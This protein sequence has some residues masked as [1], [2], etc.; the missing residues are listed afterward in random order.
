[1][2]IQQFPIIIL[3]VNAFHCLVLI[4]LNAKIEQVR[5]DEDGFGKEVNKEY[6]E[7]TNVEG[8]WPRRFNEETKEKHRKTLKANS[9]K[10]SNLNRRQAAII[11]EATLSK[12]AE[13]Y[14]EASPQ[15]ILQLYII[16]ITGV[17]S[18]SQVVTIV[19][20]VIVTTFGTMTTYLKEPT[21]V[22][23]LN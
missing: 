21:K 8:N 22:I 1:M 18:T 3:V 17:V 15:A 5:Q 20:S 4:K 16:A 9:T 10:L 12:K 23:Y 19:V 13:V 2:I 7:G 11:S 14:L 6:N